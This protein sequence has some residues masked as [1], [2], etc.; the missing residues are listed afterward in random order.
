M[1]DK[2]RTVHGSVR[3]ETYGSGDLEVDGGKRKGQEN[4]SLTPQPCPLAGNNHG[5]CHS[6][7]FQ[8]DTKATVE[9]SLS[10]YLSGQAGLR[11]CLRRI[12]G[13]ELG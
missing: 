6:V 13:T 3:K 11:T 10:E 4:T 1:Y 12:V 8:L 2:A 5:S 7:N 9:D